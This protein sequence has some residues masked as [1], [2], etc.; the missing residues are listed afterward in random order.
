MASCPLLTH[1]PAKE[2]PHA[3]TF[4]V[5]SFEQ[6]KRFVSTVTSDHI[7]RPIW[8]RNTLN[9]RTGTKIRA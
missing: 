2:Q 9:I 4:S 1:S 5:N 6:P 7:L 8:N 3:G